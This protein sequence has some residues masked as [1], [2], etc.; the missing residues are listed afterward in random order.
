MDAL[1]WDKRLGKANCKYRTILS[2]KAVHLMATNC[3][4]YRGRVSKRLIRCESPS[5]LPYSFWAFLDLFIENQKTGRN[6]RDTEW[7]LFKNL[8]EIRLRIR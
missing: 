4:H 1:S 7:T 5:A 2:W 6:C 8:R 3:S